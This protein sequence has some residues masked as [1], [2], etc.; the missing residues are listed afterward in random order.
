M[1]AVS[2]LRYSAGQSGQTKQAFPNATFEAL[3]GADPHA[4]PNSALPGLSRQMLDRDRALSAFYSGLGP[5]FVIE[6]R[7]D[8]RLDSMRVLTEARPSHNR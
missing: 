7:R 3:F 2:T 6:L 1:S 8:G 5:H 4:D